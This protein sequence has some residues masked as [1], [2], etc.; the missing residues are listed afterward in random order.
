MEEDIIMINEL[1]LDTQLKQLDEALR[2]DIDNFEQVGNQFISGEISS[3]EYKAT[4]GGMGVYAQRGGKEFMIRLRALSGVLD[5]DTMR[6][7][8]S[9][10]E[11][12][13]I[14]FVH[15][16]TRQAIQ[17]HNLQHDDVVDIMRKSH[18]HSLITR[19]SGG[20]FPRN[21]SLS[22]LSG[23]A[24][25]EA[26]DVT[27]YAVLVNKYFLSRINTYKL[28]RK[29]KVAFSNNSE[30]TAQTTI[31]DL[32]FLA[33]RKNE[34]NYFKVSLGGSLGVEGDISVPFDELVPA[35]DIFYHVEALLRL[36]TTEG[37]YENKSKARMR[38]IIKRMGREEFLQCYRKHLSDVKEELSLDF[39]IEQ[40]KYNSI[41]RE[42]KLSAS[43]GKI[44]DNS[45]LPTPEDAR[46]LIS[47]R[48][49]G[50]YTVIIHPQGGLLLTEDYNLILDF[51][52][53]NVGAQARLS[54]EESLYIRNLNIEQA[55]EL[56][57]L[58]KEIRMKTRLEQSSSCI[59]VPTCQIGVQESQ[60]L[61]GDILSYFR[62]IGFTEDYLPALHISGCMNSC[63][64]HQVN[65]IG[66]RGKKKR[67][68]E[69]M[70]DVYT[71]FIGGKTSEEDTY[72]AKEY[73][74]ILA[75]RIPAFLYEL[76]LQLKEKNIEFYA[77]RE[78][79][80]EEFHA[81][82]DSYLV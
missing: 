18:E 64:R 58:T 42:G 53:K 76:A 34:R 72:L 45:V 13:N 15:F 39:E 65:E 79:Y 26:F 81:I 21:V 55:K 67:V 17:L 48:Q 10:L 35:E 31:A 29:F 66:F 69:T 6:L 61:L 25:E 28:P 38:F 63:G 75:E 30:D 12:H 1:L 16:T 80:K 11:E 40:E 51:L 73:G 41:T 54:M 50:L 36:F 62:K 27:P 20:N 82:L 44:K 33:V 60:K 68:E 19:G 56:L 43:K 77:Y 70:K 59:G 5:I 49:E 52:E 14:P 24:R 74:D 46:N 2:K 23:V 8:G 78:K 47:Q 9:F 32:G 57:E 4:S 7:V 37:D 71:L 3:L 22:P